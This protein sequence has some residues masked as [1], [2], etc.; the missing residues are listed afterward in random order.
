MSFLEALAEA[1]VNVSATKNGGRVT[2]DGNGGLFGQRPQA[3]S[4]QGGIEDML[5]SIL[6]GQTQRPAQGGRAQDGLGGLLEQLSQLSQGQSGQSAPS[7]GGLDDLLGQLTAGAGGQSGGLGSL[8]GA[9]TG[10]GAVATGTASNG[11]FGDL[12]NQAIS[13]RGQ[14]QRVPQPS[15]PQEAAAGLMLRAMIQAAKSDGK[16]DDAEQQKLLGR[17]GDVDSHERRFVNDE[18]AKPVDVNGLAGDV[19]RGLENQVYAMSVLGIDLDNQNEARYL[20]ALAKALRI[21]Q[22][23]AN[24]IHAQVGA[25]A[26][27]R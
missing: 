5:G 19:P 12:L 18:L 16:F 23:T 14:P 21:D 13:N 17:L 3:T 9:L 15:A 7:G 8:I 10:G 26:L 2:Q 6:G 20:D 24:Q 27:Y 11:S 25:P 4:G 22:Q 1:V